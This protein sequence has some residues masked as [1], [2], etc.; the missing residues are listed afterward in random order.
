MG[1]NIYILTFITI[2]CSLNAQFWSHNFESSGGYTASISEFSDGS[3][4]YWG[5]IDLTNKVMTDG[6]G[7]GNGASSVSGFGGDWVFGG[8][9]INGEGATLPVNIVFDDIDISDKLKL[10]FK[11]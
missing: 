9:D 8:C 11:N 1:K 6:T 2:T 3:E 7:I 5:R 10:L 4:D